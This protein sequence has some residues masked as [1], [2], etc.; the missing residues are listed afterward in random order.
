MK[1]TLRLGVCALLSFAALQA[2]ADDKTTCLD[3]AARG[4]TLRDSHKLIEARESFRLCAQRQCPSVVQQDCA[5]W[6]DAVERSLATVVVTAKDTA[7]VDLVDVIVRLD[8][9]PFVTRLDGSAVP[10]NPGRHTFHFQLADGTNLDQPMVVKEGEKNQSVAVVLKR[11]IAQPSSTVATTPGS[12]P[13]FGPNDHE[14]SGAFPS[15][16]VGWVLAGVGVVGMGIGTA[17]GLIAI[18]DKNSANCGP[19]NVCQAG[20]LHSAR[21]AALI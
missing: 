18:G 6:L 11:P 2:R 20:P 13:T 12:T 7:G 10:V 16:T 21:D 19:D 5:G 15:K 17:F 8:G 14:A 3:A 1:I 4:Q 9:Q